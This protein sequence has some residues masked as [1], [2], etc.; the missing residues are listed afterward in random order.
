MKKTKKILA[1]TIIGIV[2]AICL[3][4]IGLIG[5]MVS[6]MPWLARIIIGCGMLF[7]MAFMWAVNEIDRTGD[8]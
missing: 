4:G 7:V 5:L 1:W 8:S 2:G 3:A 6:M